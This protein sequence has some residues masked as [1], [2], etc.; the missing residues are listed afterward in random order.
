[1]S[2]SS[3]SR[4]IFRISWRALACAVVIRDI[5]GVLCQ[6]VPNDLTDGM[7]S[8]LLQRRVYAL[9]THLIFVLDHRRHL[10]GILS[11]THPPPFGSK[12]YIYA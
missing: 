10:A 4:S 8:F 3:S 1:M 7:I 12:F 9:Q 2:L 6:Y 5:G 11:I